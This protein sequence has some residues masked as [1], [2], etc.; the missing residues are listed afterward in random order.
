MNNSVS[1]PGAPARPLQHLARYR[2][3]SDLPRTWKSDGNDPKQPSVSSVPSRRPADKDHSPELP[4]LE[5]A[6][7]EAACGSPQLW[8]GQLPV[9]AL[10]QRPSLP[11]SAKLN[12]ERT[13]WSVLWES[14]FSQFR[15]HFC[16]FSLCCTARTQK[17]EADCIRVG[18]GRLTGLMV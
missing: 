13:S 7:S 9:V 14:L 6:S 16:C 3:L 4:R 5:S 11:I 10:D 1:W 12:S 2:G 15:S 17:L 18:L 8:R